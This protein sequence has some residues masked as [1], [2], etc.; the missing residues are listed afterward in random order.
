MKLYCYSCKG[1]KNV[2]VLQK[3]T[4]GSDPDD[5]YDWT[6]NHYF[7]QCQGCDSIFYATE[8]W[9]EDSFDPHTGQIEADWKFYPHSATRR[10]PISDSGQFP[11]KIQRIYQE[12]IGSMNAQLPILAGIGLRALIEA[13]C[14]DQKITG[15]NLEKLIDGM[16]TAGVLSTSQATI[17]HSH[18]YLGNAAAHEVTPANPKELIA[19]LEIA[20][21]V[22]KTIYILPGLSAS[23]T[24]GKKS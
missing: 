5:G 3:A 4:I 16:A 19:A 22:L 2:N 8:S 15:G 7:V 18:R 9:G 20:E 10:E 1:A 23:I 21:T 17:L 11:Y 6:Q 13:I 14:K 24:T 12:V